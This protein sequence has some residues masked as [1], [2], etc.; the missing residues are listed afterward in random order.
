MSSSLIQ[1]DAVNN[2]LLDQ[3]DVL[4]QRV[5]RLERYALLEIPPESIYKVRDY[6]A[7]GDGV[8]NDTAAI[9]AAWDAM[10]NGDALWFEPGKTYL[11]ADTLLFNNNLT[12]VT[13]YGNAARIEVDASADMTGKPV[14]NLAGSAYVNWYDLRI[15]APDDTTPPVVGL[16][17]GRTSTFHGSRQ[18]F[19]N[20]LISGYFTFAAYYN[21]GS[22][23]SSFHKCTFENYESGGHAA[24]I[25]NDD[26]QSLLDLDSGQLTGTYVNC[27]FHCFGSDPAKNIYMRGAV[28]DQVFVGCYGVV[29][30]GGHFIYTEDGDGSNG[31]ISNQFKGI[32]IE[33]GNEDHTD[34]RIFYQ[35]NASATCGDF[36]FE[37][38]QFAGPATNAPEY[39]YEIVKAISKCSFATTNNFYGK[40]MLIKSTATVNDCEVKGNGTN[41]VTVESGATMTGN[42]FLWTRG[43]YPFD[44]TPSGMNLAQFCPELIGSLVNFS[45]GD[46]TPSVGGGRF[47]KTN[48]TNPTT[49]TDFDDA[50]PGVMFYVLSGDFNTTL[51]FSGTN[52]KGNNGVDY[53]LV[54]PD[55]VRVVPLA[56]STYKYC[57]II[58]A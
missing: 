38:I 3:I 39:H 50:V 55:M 23:V 8:T 29:S 19:Y 12:F 41:Q 58:Q 15:S 4:Q 44:A 33:A 48:N 42:R 51:D 2:N 35:N 40:T 13:V 30:P 24:Y 34:S 16:L 57:E 20:A 18:G 9:Q 5:A 52:L 27:V 6:G 43:D 1:R 45:D 47:F 25:S 21:V 7:V 46:T 37:N 22:E 14:I 56:G 54:Y 28:S 32:R 36:K 53:T 17:L 11:V 10:S 31:M 49:I 26:I